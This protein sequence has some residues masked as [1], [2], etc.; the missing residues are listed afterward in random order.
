MKVLQL[1]NIAD[2]NMAVAEL[3]RRVGLDL[4]ASAR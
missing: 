1:R 3:S 2:F 4:S